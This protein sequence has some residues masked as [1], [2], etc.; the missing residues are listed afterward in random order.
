MVEYGTKLGEILKVATE[1][2]KEFKENREM[3]AKVASGIL[4]S[5]NVGTFNF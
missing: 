1:G 2:T 4:S 5:T 3:A